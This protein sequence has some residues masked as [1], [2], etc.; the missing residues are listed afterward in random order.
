MGNNRYK[1]YAA[2][3]QKIRKFLLIA[4][5]L[6][7]I[8]YFAYLFMY[9]EEGYMRY[10]ELKATQQD[11]NQEIRNIELEKKQILK[12]IH[13]IRKDPYAMEGHAREMGYQQEGEVIYKFKE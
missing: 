3:S 6:F 1:K 4:V 5:M 11:M 10:Q 2:Q 9:G 7:I 8:G 13:V 12:E